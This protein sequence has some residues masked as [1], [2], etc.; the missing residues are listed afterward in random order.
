[1]F[2][3]LLVN[4]RGYRSKE[5][6][7][8]KTLKKWKPSMVIMNETQL[9]GN[10][11]V[12]LEP[13]YMSW[14][15][16]RTAQAGG[17]VATAVA[18]AYMDKSWG[19]GEGVGSDEYIITRVTT[20]TPA[21]NVVNCYGEQKKTSKLEIE[22]K[23]KRLCRDLEDIR[24]RNELCI[25]CGDLNKW[26]GNG[27]LGVPGNHPELSV[28]GKLL[29]ELL[30]TR[31]WVLVNGLGEEVVSG[32]PFTRQDPATGT[33]SCLDL[34]VVSKEV[35]PY[36][37]KLEIDSERKMDIARVERNK[38]KGTF[39]MVYPDHFPVLL[40]LTNLPLEKE[41]HEEKIVRWNLAKDGGWEEYRKESEKIKEKLIRVVENHEISIEEKKK[42]IDKIHNKVKYKSFGKVTITQNRKEN[43]E[44]KLVDEKEEADEETKARNLWEGQV[45]RVEKEM[46]EIDHLRNGKVGK[47]WEVKKRIIG[48]KKANM[49]ATAI[50]NPDTGKLAMSKNETLTATLKYCKDTLQ[51]NEPSK[52]FRNAINKKKKRGQR[53]STT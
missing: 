53:F 39:R 17:G 10:M 21:L 45:A 33:F 28:G 1:M 52:E 18:R 24:A 8:K 5:Y 7:L 20:F 22:E 11:K 48:G 14:S 40:T 36:I 31:N 42:E 50:I 26:V 43:C 9:R 44:K 35:V 4:L 49:Q 15:K 13:S 6:S 19:A 27:E 2:S 38:K 3:I 12:S 29:R 23:W 46:K 47:I 30:A 34:F 32:G 51:N 25:F 41:V 37:S 16:N